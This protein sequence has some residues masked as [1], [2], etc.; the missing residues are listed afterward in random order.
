MQSNLFVS[1]DIPKT[2][3][4]K[5]VS[6][7]G[8]TNKALLSPSKNLPIPNAPHCVEISPLHGSHLMEQKQNNNNAL[9]SFQT[10]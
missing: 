1:T 8:M 6:A 3:D 4:C 5:T 2:Y 9:E 7:E 10:L